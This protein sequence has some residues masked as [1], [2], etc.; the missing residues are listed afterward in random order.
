MKTPESGRASLA[1]VARLRQGAYRLLATLLLY[2][3]QERLGVAPD[4]ARYL[5]RRSPWAAGLAFYGPWDGLLRQVVNL[6]P[7]QLD[8]LGD[9]YSTLFVGNTTRGAV[10]LCESAYVDPL[11]MSPGQ[12]LA[13]VE[14]AYAAA[15]LRPASGG[16]A[17]DHAAVELEFA[18]FL[19][20]Q[21]AEAWEA[22]LL[23]KALDALRLQKGFLEQHLGRWLELPCR[24]VAARDGRSFYARVLR[25]AWALV[26]HDADLV[27][28]LASRA[29]AL[30]TSRA[31]A[32]QC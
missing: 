5:R 32:V 26:A 28:A 30:M 10:S 17:P 16:E 21:E 18:S 23:S 8:A 6:G 27:R 3:S 31:E 29:Q 25:A 1:D 4:A 19:C 12:V 9:A 15:G 13:Q 2:P 11:A 7:A 24:G 20:G 22:A 14:A